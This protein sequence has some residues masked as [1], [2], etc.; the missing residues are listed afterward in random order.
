MF[1]PVLG[2]AF[3]QERV[4][5][6]SINLLRKVGHEVF[7]FGD[8]VAGTIPQCEKVFPLEGLCD[9]HPLSPKT[10][11]ADMHEKVFSKLSDVKPDLIHFIDQFDARLMHNAAKAYPCVFTAHTVA[12][13]CPSSQRLIYFNQVEQLNSVCSKKSGWS[14]LFYNKMFGCLSGF[15]TDA[16]RAHAIY[17]YKQKRSALGEFKK[18]IAISQFVKEMLLKDGFDET[19]IATVYNPVEVAPV[20]PLKDVPTNLIVCASRLVELKGVDF[21][22]HALKKI[23]AEKYTLWICGDGPLRA[24]L[25]NLVGSLEMNSRIVFKGRTSR[26]ETTR[27]LQAASIVVQPNIGPEGFGLTVAE[28]QS[29]GKP[30]VAYNIP[31]LNEIIQDEETGLLAKPKS[32]T[33]LSEKIERLLKDPTLAAR[34]GA[35]G[36]ERMRNRFSPQ[37]HLNATLEV[38]REC[39]NESVVPNR[40][41]ANILSISAE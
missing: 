29:L 19:K 12:P 36:R 30:V 10:E 14:C 13:T 16:H 3:G 4:M 22:V 26:E 9:I 27:I 8:T 21:L 17:H 23:T 2:D 38:Y 1:S 20:E 11:V 35:A 37:A 31:A 33:D 6:D 34:F 25:T 28:A 24:D 39:T 5:R 41:D 40:K 32:V 18:I 15:K 7:L